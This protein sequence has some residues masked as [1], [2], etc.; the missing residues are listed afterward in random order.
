MSRTAEWM[1]ERYLDKLDA[2]FHAKHG[3]WPTD[4]EES[5]LWDEAFKLAAQDEA[6]KKLELE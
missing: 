2:E 1:R 4:E 5:A 3:R 6:F